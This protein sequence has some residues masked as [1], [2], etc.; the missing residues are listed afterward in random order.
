MMLFPEP[1]GSLASMLTLI[2][3]AIKFWRFLSPKAR[4]ALQEARDH[5]SSDG[6]TS[7][8]Q[9]QKI[10]LQTLHAYVSPEEVESISSD[11]THANEVMTPMVNVLE[12]SRV[13]EVHPEYGWAL[14]LVV[15]AAYSKL[16]SW[17]CFNAWAHEFETYYG[18]IDIL[19][20]IYTDASIRECK[21][22]IRN[23]KGCARRGQLYLVNPEQLHRTIS[24]AGWVISQRRRG[25]STGGLEE[26]I[27]CFA[28][29]GVFLRQGAYIS[30]LGFS[31]DDVDI[32]N[33]ITTKL[34]TRG[35]V[36][37]QGGSH[38]RQRCRLGYQDLAIIVGGLLT[39][40]V[41]YSRLLS[42]E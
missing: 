14:T 3:S 30:T 26:G 5:L 35:R 38:S 1:A 4:Q 8:S 31:H 9:A 22:L 19:P 32:Q 12:N 27:L 21:N 6:N 15:N 33:V 2:D 23:I 25:I 17:R 11:I 10:L 20:M 18:P 36:N 7:S 39:D 28:N 37:I 29:K 16:K 13:K 41:W 34:R 40:V 42:I 24:R